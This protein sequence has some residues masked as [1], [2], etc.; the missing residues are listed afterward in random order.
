MVLLGCFIAAEKFFESIQCKMGNT[1]DEERKLERKLNIA[2]LIFHA[3][4][5][6]YNE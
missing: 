4:G 1:D 5:I 3:I 6:V 2:S